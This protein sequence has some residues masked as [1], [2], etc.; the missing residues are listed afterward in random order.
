M[1]DRS[2][3]RLLAFARK[4]QNAATFADLL[5]TAHDEVLEVTGYRNVWFYVANPEDTRELKLIEITSKQR[6][7]VWD[8]AETLT[9]DSDPLIQELLNGDVP[10]IIPD[11]RT[12][13]R[14]NKA[15]VNRLQNR[16]LINIPL[17][18]MDQPFGAF[19]LGTYGDEG[20][21]APTEE[22]LDYL[23]G[24]ASQIVVAAGRIRFLELRAKAG[25]DRQEFERRLTQ[26]QKLESLGMLAG[27]I[28]HDFNNLLTVVAVSSTLALERTVDAQQRSDIQAIA[29]AARRGEELTRQLLAMSRAQDLELK[30]IDINVQVKEL[31]RLARRILPET[32]EIDFIEATS[33]PSVDADPSQLGQVFLNLLINARDAMPDGG[34][35]TIESQQ[36]LVNGR[37]AATHPWA[38]PGRYVLVTI[39]DT[40][41]GMTR[42]VQ[43]RIFE[44]FF[45]TKGPRVGTGL[46]LAVVYGIVQQHRGMVHCY[47]EVG[48]GTS[49]KVYIPALEQLAMNVGSQLRP[50]PTGGKESVLLAEDD[51]HV[52]AVAVKILERAGYDVKAVVDGDSAC[53]AVAKDRF[54]L[55]VLDVVMPGLLCRET[56]AR[57]RSLHPEIPVVLS[58]GYA[59]GTNI[60]ALVKLTG[61]E[62]LTKPYDPDRLLHVVRS[63]LDS[64]KNQ[65]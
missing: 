61:F 34:R 40:G 9:V 65:G 51:E 16:T 52:R 15:I 26:A 22:Q 4:L 11:A 42:E 41:V 2:M 24:M 29:E 13:P 1:S 12:D 36:V 39:T 31:L 47:S 49:F 33:L 60:S 27:G 28:A 5:Q 17:R 37:Y 46:G 56:L 23:L 8:V 25:K 57:I 10:I 18:L 14:T 45:T 50:Q 64:R 53:C 59:A 6:Q 54:D 55:V 38:K 21:R 62:L 32:I 48:V 58:S 44:P 19:G 35:V 20:V 30:P 3:E 7:L 63:A 43:D